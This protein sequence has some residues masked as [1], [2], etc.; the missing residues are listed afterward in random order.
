MW[1]QFDSTWELY[2]ILSFSIALT[3]CSLDLCS[4]CL[5]AS[6]LP[7]I[8]ELGG[9]KCVHIGGIGHVFTIPSFRSSVSEA[10]VCDVLFSVCLI[11]SHLQSCVYVS[12]WVVIFAG[13]PCTFVE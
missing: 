10:A 12:A 4:Y 7:L 6:N 9:A 13:D 3:L 2:R 8:F 1:P 11:G 5:Y